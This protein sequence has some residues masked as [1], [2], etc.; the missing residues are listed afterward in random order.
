MTFHW[1]KGSAFF[2]A[3]YELRK[4]GIELENKTKDK[5]ITWAITK[6][7]PL[8]E[9]EY[10]RQRNNRRNR[11]YTNKRYYNDNNNNMRGFNN[12]EFNRT[13]NNTDKDWDE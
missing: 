11:K 4:L 8:D 1:I 6:V 3:Q 9:E 7:E 2:M 5:K 10:K 13:N 12:N